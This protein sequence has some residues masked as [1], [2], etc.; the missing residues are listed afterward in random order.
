MY[1]EGKGGKEGG[2]R[3]REEREGESLISWS[4]LLHWR[5]RRAPIS[6]CTLVRI[7]L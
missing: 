2:I 4:P 1:C 6:S 5:I 3:E 7:I